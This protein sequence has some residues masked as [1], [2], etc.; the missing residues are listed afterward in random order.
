MD[1]QKIG[2]IA[3][4]LGTT[5][6]IL[7]W[8]IGFSIFC[9]TTGMT[10]L[11]ARVFIPGLVLSLLMACIIVAMMELIVQ[12]F[13]FAHYALQLSL[14][15]MLTSVIGLL[16]FILNH[17][18]GPLISRHPQASKKLTEIGSV[19]QTSDTVPVIL[20]SVGVVLLFFL[21]IL[22]FRQGSKK[23]G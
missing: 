16:W 1:G 20:M 9:L 21:V 4:Y 5:V 15:A 12:R 2:K 22:I 10:D 11:L 14:W 19:Y 3:G 8:L 18:L 23:T 6:G 17:W 13:G 7:G